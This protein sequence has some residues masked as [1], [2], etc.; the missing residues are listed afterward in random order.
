MSLLEFILL[1]EVYVK[2]YNSNI[3]I[4][5]VITFNYVSINIFEHLC[6]VYV[7]VTSMFC[8]LILNLVVSLCKLN[9]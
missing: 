6:M 5:K 9:D 1:K 3:N 7:T 8:A 4:C 2:K